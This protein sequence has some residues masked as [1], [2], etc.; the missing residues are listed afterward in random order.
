MFGVRLRGWKRIGR[1]SPDPRA[2]TQTASGEGCKDGHWK[3][4]QKQRRVQKRKQ[5]SKF[6]TLG[7]I[8]ENIEASKHA[9][10]LSG[11]TS[12]IVENVHMKHEKGREKIHSESSPFSQEIQQET[13]DTTASMK[14]SETVSG[15]SLPTGISHLL[16]DYQ[17]TSVESETSIL[18]TSVSSCL[19]PEIPRGAD[20]FDE[21]DWKSIFHQE[22]LFHKNSTLLETSQAVNIDLLAEPAD[23]SNIFEPFDKVHLHGIKS[24]KKLKN[25]STF[26][27]QHVSTVVSG[28]KVFKI[29][30][31]KE[32]TPKSD[33]GSEPK[34]HTRPEKKI[35]IRSCTTDKNIKCKKRVSF[36]TFLTTE[37]PSNEHID[38][39]VGK[40]IDTSA[41]T[42]LLEQQKLSLSLT[43]KQT[44]N[45]LP[46][47]LKQGLVLTSTPFA[48]PED[49][50]LD[51]SPVCVTSMEEELIPNASGPF[52]HSSQIAASSS[53]STLK[54]SEKQELHETKQICCIIKAPVCRCTSK[55][56]GIPVAKQSLPT[57][58]KIPKDIILTF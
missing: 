48:C 30:R 38:Q 56:L 15:I 35:Q 55:I 45:T 13:Y 43:Q 18:S 39:C 54:E 9:H 4:T 20:S 40:N 8:K 57:K 50:K 52:V 7:K 19:S 6:K 23:V 32:K 17:L 44:E 14:N 16:Q 49:I 11:S 34:C 29:T 51:L 28:K 41:K 36:S 25:Y 12:E 42:D 21:S 27:K 1:S 10:A 2:G 47:S 3:A 31:E 26:E 58:H 22:N 5:F 53:L 37:I 24:D 33:G 46:A